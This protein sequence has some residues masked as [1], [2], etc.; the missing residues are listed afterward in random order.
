MYCARRVTHIPLWVQGHQHEHILPRNVFQKAHAQHSSSCQV[1]RCFHVSQGGYGLFL[2]VSLIIKVP[3]LVITKCITCH[4]PP[5]RK[6]DC[7]MID[8]HLCI[9]SDFSEVPRLI[10]LK[11]VSLMDVKQ[12]FALC[13]NMPNYYIYFFV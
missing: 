13:H 7:K 9:R 3:L 4:P 8:V 11:L 1:E 12:I 6:R 5:V 10:F 2:L